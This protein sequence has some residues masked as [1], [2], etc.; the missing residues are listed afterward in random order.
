MDL[1]Q[2]L[3]LEPLTMS[4]ESI[5]SPLT[6]SIESINSPLTSSALEETNELSRRPSGL[7]VRVQ[8]IYDR[9]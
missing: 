9:G 2:L 7:A 6:M 5:N 3:H 4:I 8:R 1:D